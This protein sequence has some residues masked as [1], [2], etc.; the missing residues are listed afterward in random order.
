MRYLLMAVVALALAA[1]PVGL[2]AGDSPMP[3][4]PVGDNGGCDP[5]WLYNN[6]SSLLS[7][8]VVDDGH[9]GFDAYTRCWRISYPYPSYTQGSDFEHRTVHSPVK[10]CA[11][12]SRITGLWTTV[13]GTGGS[14]CD[15]TGHSGWV[16]GGGVG[17]AQITWHA[18]ASFSCYICLIKFTCPPVSDTIWMEIRYGVQGGRSAVAWG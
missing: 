1:V 14:F 4:C 5:D 13:T 11:K 8:S 12:N 3:S 7:G 6:G 16:S 2:A 15:N 18:Q 10:W 9:G 17:T